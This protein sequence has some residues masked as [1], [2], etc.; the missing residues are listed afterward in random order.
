MHCVEN[1][2]DYC[3]EGEE[4]QEDNDEDASVTTIDSIQNEEQRDDVL[5]E[6]PSTLND[7]TEYLSSLDINEDDRADGDDFDAIFSPLDGTAMFSTVCKMNHSCQPNVLVRYRAGWGKYRPLIAQCVALKYI[8]EG[9]ELCISYIDSDATLM[10]RREELENYGFE[11]SC[12]KCK[13][14]MTLMDKNKIEYITYKDIYLSIY[15]S[16]IRYGKKVLRN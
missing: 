6:S 12:D 13:S 1:S 8:Y 7:L 10:E 14:E 4:E 15:F 3:D 2:S 16:I 5:D 9:E 11:C